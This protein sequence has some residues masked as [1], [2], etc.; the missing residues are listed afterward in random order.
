ML[1]KTF[2]NA[3]NL[4]CQ[5]KDSSLLHSPSCLFVPFC[6][7]TVIMSQR[8]N[9]FQDK[10]I[11]SFV[12]PPRSSVK[13][14]R[15]PEPRQEPQKKEQQQRCLLAIVPLISGRAWSETFRGPIRQYSRLQSLFA[16]LFLL[17]LQSKSNCFMFDQIYRKK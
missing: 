17:I 1:L 7:L 9:V 13:H 2:A 4:F 14:R 11:V 10:L 12:C 15:L 16:R 8:Q 5:S 3:D 6:L